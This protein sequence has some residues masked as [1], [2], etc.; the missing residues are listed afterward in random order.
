MAGAVPDE[1]TPPEEGQ[2][3]L[4]MT[5]LKLET[6]LSGSLVTDVIDKAV[7]FFEGRFFGREE[8]CFSVPDATAFFDASVESALSSF[9]LSSL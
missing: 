1:G 9:L 2:G 7:G 8:V 4:G 6:G 5:P 3:F